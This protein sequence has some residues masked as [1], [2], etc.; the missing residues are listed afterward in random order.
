L[1]MTRG[2]IYFRGERMHN[3]IETRLKEFFKDKEYIPIAYLFGSY[4]KDKECEESDID[5][6]IYIQDKDKLP[7]LWLELERLININVDLVLINSAPASLVWSAI[8]RGIP[9]KIKDRRL[10]LSIMLNAS[11]EA[12]DF[13][14]FNL[15]TFFK[16]EKR[17]VYDRRR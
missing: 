12:E 15:D 5:I 1:E 16:K 6:A 7:K 10:F 2:I 9:L 11:R 13:L 3:G 8:R 14:D 4:A 17:R